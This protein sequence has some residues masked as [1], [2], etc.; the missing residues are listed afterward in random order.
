MGVGA[1]DHS[2]QALMR[3]SRL[4]RIFRRSGLFGWQLR[5]PV[6]A[7]LRGGLQDPW[8]GDAG[9]GT[10]IIAGE[11]AAH[12]AGLSI[13]GFAGFEWLRDL[14]SAGDNQARSRARELI[15]QWVAANQKWQ[16]P[17][18]RP[19]V[20]GRRLAQLAMNYSWYGASASESFQE[21]LAQSVEM[22]I[23]CLAID[24]RRVHPLDAQVA[25][26]CGLA[27]AE[28]EMSADAARLAALEEMVTSRLDRLVL[29]DGGHV[30]RM[31]DRH[32]ALMRRLVELRM[33][34][35]LA[36]AETVGLTATLNRM[37]AVA[38]MWRHGDGAG[39]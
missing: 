32:V 30:S 25:A 36:G 29:P 23:R 19:D 26:L 24:W 34:V 9:S 5:G 13:Y 28:V 22:Q 31:P 1:Q 2:G 12:D 14:R 21:M 17:D 38:R 18:W 8:F 27:L 39:F 15:K 6:R 33:A 35:S 7:R 37:G 4:E 20:M 16:L 3:I 10:A 11:T